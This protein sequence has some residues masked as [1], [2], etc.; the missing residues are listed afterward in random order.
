MMSLPESMTK[1]ILY[2]KKKIHYLNI[3]FVIQPEICSSQMLHSKLLQVTHIL[4]ALKRVPRIFIS[5]T[6]KIIT[7]FLQVF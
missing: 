2:S 4:K 6:Y 7:N 3:Q 1:I 5:S